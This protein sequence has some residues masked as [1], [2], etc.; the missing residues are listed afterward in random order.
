MTNDCASD[1]LALLL[2]KHWERQLRGGKNPTASAAVKTER[3]LPGPGGG[4]M[5]KTA[6][7]DGSAFPPAGAFGE[8]RKAR[9][10]ESH[11][12]YHHGP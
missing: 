2:R 6:P 11:A 8:P 7:G 9:E 10:G 5:E 3:R 4:I 1:A 12:V